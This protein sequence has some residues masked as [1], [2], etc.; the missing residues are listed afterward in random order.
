MSK[1]YGI[2]IIPVS[3][4]EIQD[5]PNA[6][7][8]KGFVHNENI[9]INTDNATIDTPIHEMMHIFLG[10]VRYSDPNTYF[11]LVDSVEQLDRY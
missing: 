4:E 3:T 7:V 2:N 1:L 10:G 5:I 9:Y 6:G 8:V 11:R